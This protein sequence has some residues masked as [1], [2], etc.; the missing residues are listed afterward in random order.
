MT[1]N[2]KACPYCGEEILAV[3]VKCKHCGSMLSAAPSAVAA[4]SSPAAVS[5][6]SYAQVPWYRKNWLAIVCAF[7]FQPGLLAMAAT[8]NIYYQRG[9]Q[10]RTYGKFARAFVLIWGIVGTIWLI[11]RVASSEPRRELTS[12]PVHESVSVDPAPSAAAV[13]PIAVSATPDDLQFGK[14]TVTKNYGMTEVKVM[15]KNVSG[16]QVTCTLTATFLRGDT[17]L[18][19]AGGVVNDLAPGATKTSELMTNDTVKGYDTLKLEPS[20]CF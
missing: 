15:V 20:A 13:V 12:T 16:K 9:G 7:F 14:P 3:A 10:L 2:V 5:P 1:E 6:M 11:V 8:G 4:G 18:G 17:I 19:T